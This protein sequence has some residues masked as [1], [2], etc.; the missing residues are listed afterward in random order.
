MF[1]EI[2]INKNHLLNNL[3][4]VK[5]K[6]PNSKI[7]AMVKANAY[8]VGGKEVVQVLNEHVD[9]FGVACFFE[10]KNLKRLTNKSILICGAVDKNEI[11]KEFSYSCGNLEDLKMFISTNQHLKV[12]L[13]INTGMNRYGFKSLN[14]FKNAL[15][16]IKKGNLTVEGLYTHFA[17]TDEFA[18]VQ[19]QRFQKFIDLCYSNGFHPIVHADNSFVNEKFNHNLDMVRIGFNLFNRL[20]DEFC[21]VVSIKSN[22]VEVQKVDENGLVGYNYRFVA[23]QKIKIGI[24]PIGYADGFD[25][26]Y[27]G[28][29]LFVNNTK[30]KVLNICMD[31]LMLDITN[32]QLKKGDEIFIL[33]EFN[34]LKMYADFINTNEYEIMTKFSY[35]RAR[36]KIV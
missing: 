3:K 20:S 32:C 33:N 9:F 16:M 18:K 35:L 25:M 11:K 10:A 19:M 29:E 24:V 21:P 1:N 12:H 15:K 5:K 23:K 36:R 17:T 14:E 6:N 31:C 28:I 22:I 34:S 2:L 27:L 26:R 8:G 13:K 30:C 7:C 4:Q